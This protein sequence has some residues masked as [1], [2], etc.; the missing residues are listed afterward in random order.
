[1]DGPYCLSC[2][3][4]PVCVPAGAGWGGGVQTDRPDCAKWGIG[5]PLP[6]GHEGK[7]R[8]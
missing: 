7:V 4:E 1:M 3:G 5:S 8:R 2:T 6:Q